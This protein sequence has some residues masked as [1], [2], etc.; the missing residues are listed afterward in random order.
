MKK[1]LIAAA[2]AAAGMLVGGVGVALA[3]GPSAPQPADGVVYACVNAAGNIEYVQFRRPA[4]EPDLTNWGNCW[5][6][7]GGLVQWTWNQ[8]GPAGADG[9]D[10]QDGQNGVSGYEVFTSVQDFSPR[11]IGG[12][13][14][15]APNANTE[16]QGWRVIGGGAQLTPE[17]V[18][19]GIT[20]ISSWP[21]L[22]DPLNPGWNVQ[23]G[24]PPNVNPGEVTLYAVCALAS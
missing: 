5:D 22:D 8:A 9:A 20:V 1:I 12:A 14:C 21:N 18:N 23:V 2:V 15:G 16:D 17:D 4:S 6:G 13:W 24:A 19:A 11:G 3:Q 7:P 10:G